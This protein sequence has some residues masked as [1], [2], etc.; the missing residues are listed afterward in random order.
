MTTYRFIARHKGTEVCQ[1]FFFESLKEA[2][3]RNPNYVDWEQMEVM[4]NEYKY[5]SN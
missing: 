4:S 1:E 3:K 2:K 5:K